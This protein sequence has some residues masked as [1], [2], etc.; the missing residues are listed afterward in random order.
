[1]FRKGSYKTKPTRA[2]HVHKCFHCYT[3]SRCSIRFFFFKMAIDLPSIFFFNQCKNLGKKCT[4]LIVSFFFLV[5]LVPENL[6]A[7]MAACF[8]Q[9]A[10]SVCRRTTTRYRYVAYLYVNAIV[11]IDVCSTIIIER[12][13]NACTQL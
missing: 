3:C 5:T 1:M 6:P 12:I 11:I 4:S 10:K 9:V 8:A 2:S 13:I 7:P